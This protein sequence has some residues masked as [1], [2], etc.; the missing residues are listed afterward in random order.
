M[1]LRSNM[2]R[3]YSLRKKYLPKRLIFIDNIF[4]EIYNV[5]VMIITYENEKIKKVLED[6]PTLQ[7]KC[8][9]HALQIKRRM[10]QLKSFINLKEFIYSGLDNPHFETGDLKGL[11][12]WDIN[13]NVRM[14]LEIK[15]TIDYDS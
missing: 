4:L 5:A 14:L 15:E 7:K 8:G 1:I 3:N 9:K 6:F 2:D 11:I 10:Q 12:G 13:Q